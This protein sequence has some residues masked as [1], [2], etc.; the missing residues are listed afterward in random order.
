MMNLEEYRTLFIGGIL[1]LVLVAASPVLSVILPMGGSERFSGLWLLGPGHLADG[2]PSNVRV[3][4]VY[5]VFVGVDNH[6]G[7]AEYYMVYVKFSDSNEFLP[8]FNGDKPSF[9]PGLYT[10]RFFVDD[11]GA[12]QSAV[13]FGFDD[14]AVEGAVLTVGEVTINGLAFP[15]DASA[16]WDS[17]RQGY[18]FDLFFELWRYDVEDNAFRFDERYVGLS[19]NM[20][21]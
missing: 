16:Y 2:Y 13:T 7:N 6:M 3:G 20:T 11:G 18:F 10:F 8:D 12:W 15:V 1:V 17:E 9:L 4:E 14:V 5:S 19:L 21:A